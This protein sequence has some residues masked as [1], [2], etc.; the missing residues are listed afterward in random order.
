[1]L[2]AID[3]RAFLRRAGNV[4]G[5]SYLSLAGCSRRVREEGSSTAAPAWASRIAA[6]EKDIPRVMDENKVPG[7]AVALIKDAK[8]A[9][10]R[11]FGV[12]DRGAGSPVDH[13]TVFEAA[14]MSKPVFAYTVMKA[15]EKG[16]LRLD[17]P[18]VEYTRE[19]FLEGDPRLDQVTARHVLC[20]TAGFQDIRSRQN[21]LKMHFRPGEKW[22]YSG[23]GYFYLQSVMTGLA[24]RVY[25][26]DC[27]RF[28]AGFEVCATDFDSYMQTNLLV[29]FG[30]N[31]SGYLWSDALARDVAHPH[32]AEGN[33]LPYRKPSA[34][35]VARY[36]AMGGLLTTVADY[37]KFLI[38]VIDP[39]P[40]DAFRLS[41][42]SLKEMLRPQVKVEV[43]QGYSIWWAL[44]WRV[45]R[46]AAGDLVSHGGDQTGFHSTSE[47][48][49]AGRSGY[50][51]LTNG[52][53]GWKVIQDI[54]PRISGWLYKI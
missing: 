8:V 21:P 54:A 44:G 45:A 50:V 25:R 43:G 2:S 51:I 14:S 39:K 5:A 4:L 13:R 10:I 38:Q 48:S 37:A 9:W 29:P 3:R 18:L 19:R 47:F 32:D 28:E 16:I 6:L 53:N 42:A 35:A 33:P 15:C 26:G 24:G 20:H 49:V 7:L 36:G 12:R 52:E 1:M 27:S 23:E 17:T 31:Q 46:T 34:A 30:M 22:A 41:G 40:E 11:G